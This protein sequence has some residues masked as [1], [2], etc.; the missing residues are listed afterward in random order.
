MYNEDELQERTY[1]GKEK[2]Y[3]NTNTIETQNEYMLCDLLRKLLLDIA[4]RVRSRC[5]GRVAGMG[6]HARKRK[7]PVR[8]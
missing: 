6:M 2:T 1:G 8:H 7:D 5:S 4:R 3:C